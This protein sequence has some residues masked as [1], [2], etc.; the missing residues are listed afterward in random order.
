MLADVSNSGRLR[1][2]DDRA[3]WVVQDNPLEAKAL[4]GLVVFA[5]AVGLLPDS[6]DIWVGAVLFLLLA[7]PLIEDRAD[8]WISRD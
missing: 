1:R 8:R 5:L 3:L 7:R 6:I 4:L 2:L